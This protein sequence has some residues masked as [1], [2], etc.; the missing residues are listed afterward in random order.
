LSDEAVENGFAGASI[1]LEFAGV[2]TRVGA[3]VSHCKPGDAVVGFGPHGFTNYAVTT[4]AALSQ[5]PENLSF[6]AAATI[7]STFFTSYYAL[8]YLAQIQA[9]EKVLIHGAAG[10]VGLAAIQ[11]ALWRGAN[12]YAT[13]GSPAKRD[14]LRLMGVANIYD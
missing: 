4:E 9:G 2:V 11:I 8:V 5:L 7:P 10:G 1:G 6:E 12:V 13:A 3:G 14:L